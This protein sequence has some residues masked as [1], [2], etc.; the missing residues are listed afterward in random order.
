MIK[1]KIILILIFLTLFSCV[2]EKKEEITIAAASSLQP[3]LQELQAQFITQTGI[4]VNLISGSSGKLTAQIESGA[5]FDIFFSAD[6][7]YTDYLQTKLNLRFLPEVFAYGSLVFVT[8][9]DF[10]K[11]DT[12]IKKILTSK[13]LKKIAIPNPKLAPYGKA[14]K[15]VLNR[16]EISD[17]IQAKLV[18]AESVGQSN[19]FLTSSS[20][21]AG[22]TSLSSTINKGFS[23]DFQVHKIPENLYKPI[24]NTILIVSKEESKIPVFKRFISFLKSN[25]AQQTLKAYG[26]TIPK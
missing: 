19:Q 10:T 1:I 21:S 15:T 13:R 20:V 4:N 7:A 8:L 2:S 26:Y 16:L 14:A 17:E 22:F 18:F 5:P 11:Q 9:S 12:S 3:V 24:I 23:K 6:S 25:K